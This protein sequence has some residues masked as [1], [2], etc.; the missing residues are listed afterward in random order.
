MTEHEIAAFGEGYYECRGVILTRLRDILDAVVDGADPCKELIE[1]YEAL[2]RE[3]DEH[4]AHSLEEL[5]HRRNREKAG[6][7]IRWEDLPPHASLCRDDL[8][9]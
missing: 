4:D 7:P 2:Q 6:A 5:E 8:G 9:A 1:L 3:E